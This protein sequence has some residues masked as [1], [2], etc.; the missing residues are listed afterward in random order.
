L[1]AGALRRFEVGEERQALFQ[2]P[3]RFGGQPARVLLQPP[4]YGVGHGFE[5]LDRRLRRHKPIVGHS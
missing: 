3:H 2:G 1:N 5:H 4:Q